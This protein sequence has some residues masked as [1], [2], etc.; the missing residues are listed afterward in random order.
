MRRSKTTKEIA[1]YHKTDAE[2]RVQLNN[3]QYDANIEANQINR[4]E[5]SIPQFHPGSLMK[6]IAQY[7][8]DD[9][10]YRYKLDRIA[11]NAVLPPSERIS[12]F[13]TPIDQEKIDFY[14]ANTKNITTPYID[15]PDLV[16]EPAS[17]ADWAAI[18]A[19]LSDELLIK[20]RIKLQ[21]ALKEAEG[22]VPRIRERLTRPML[23][24][25]KEKLEL[26]LRIYLKR[27]GT[28]P[29]KLEIISN[30]LDAIQQGRLAYIEDIKKENAELTN[31]YIKKFDDM[32]AGNLALARMAGESDEAY[33]TRVDEN[34]NALTYDDAMHDANMFISQQFIKLLKNT[35]IDLSIVEQVAN[36][37]TNIAK[38]RILKT[39]DKFLKRLND[40]AGKQLY[41]LSVDD[42]EEIINN[43]EG[44]NEGSTLSGL[45]S[46]IAD[47]NKS[48]TESKKEKKAEKLAEYFA[49]TK[50][51]EGKQRRGRS[52][53]PRKISE[54]SFSAAEEMSRNPPVLT[55][56]W[57]REKTYE[58]APPLDLG[59]EE[60]K[61]APSPLQDFRV[62]ELETFRTS[63]KIVKKNYFMELLNIP[64]YNRFVL[65]AKFKADILGGVKSW[66]DI[67][68]EKLDEEYA[69]FLELRRVSKSSVA[70]TRPQAASP[71]SPTAKKRF[72]LASMNPFISTKQED[73]ERQEGKGFKKLKRIAR[74]A[75]PI[76][77]HIARVAYDNIKKSPAFHE[78]KIDPVAHIRN[79]YI[80]DGSDYYEK[81]AKE[82]DR[83]HKKT[84]E[85]LDAEEE[86]GWGI[87]KKSKSKPKKHLTDLAA[88]NLK[89]L[90]KT[91][92]M[93]EQ[94]ITAGNDNKNMINDATLILKEMVKLKAIDTKQKNK[95]LKQL[96][97]IN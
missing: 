48:L 9:A 91:L 88:T 67:K 33:T 26:N 85:E 5:K 20:E 68:I 53:E 82:T 40:I 27:M 32:N 42:I 96:K 19:S 30:Q 80:Q 22:L 51:E 89:R 47:I 50:E 35:G 73:E 56:R 14:R 34:I 71:A 95:Y 81:R 6:Q 90:K 77:K 13:L 4:E 11:E 92:K 57:S 21:N 43:Y 52:Y 58:P 44:L 84:L 3:M 16:K 15:K 24:S 97:K 18:D 83:M 49:K 86:M 61:E 39:K 41:K 63:G 76:I 12:N 46:N 69:N 70:R 17:N 29:A 25:A 74:I 87:N 8:M 93:I 10:E 31:Q 38:E 94:E 37:L 7:H 1:D 78:D 23:K 75:K 72:S 62:L 2:I 64:K 79:K 36:R 66:G 54:I 59:E 28:M 55:G 65:D 45:Q 60:G